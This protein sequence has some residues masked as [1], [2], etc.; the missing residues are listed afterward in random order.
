MAFLHYLVKLAG[1][2]VS[3]AQLTGTGDPARAGARA[4]H[5]IA[6]D[7]LPYGHA[8]RPAAP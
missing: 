5:R 8:F 4:G 1:Y 6:A 3:R 2:I 7:A